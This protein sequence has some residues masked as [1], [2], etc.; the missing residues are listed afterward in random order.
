MIRAVLH[1]AFF[2]AVVTTVTA[3][4]PIDK[5]VF[6]AGE[7]ATYK[8]Y[9][10]WGFVWL[11]A[12]DVYFNV[13]L[14][15]DNRFYNLTSIGQSLPKYDWFYKVRDTF[16]SRVDTAHLLPYFY[17]RKTSEGG[18]KVDNSYRFSYSNSKLYTR[19]SNSDEELQRDTFNFKSCTFDVLSAVYYTRSIDFSNRRV[20]EKIPLSFIIDNEFHDLYI[21]YLGKENV[22]TRAGEEYR[23][24]KFSILLVEGTVF[25]GG[26]D[27]TVWVT[28]DANHIPVLVEA[29]ILVGSVKAY[30]T[31][32]KES[33]YPLRALVSGTPR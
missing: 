9:Y 7:T 29:K 18:Y 21:R 25:E 17:H 15:A 4:C 24:I 32:I 19:V 8:A 10:N 30:L 5:K 26:E 2:L 16:R 13:E 28:D 6:R 20:D 22:T 1:I 23:C 33:K 3:Q 11:E 12:A 14:S 27:M 31:D